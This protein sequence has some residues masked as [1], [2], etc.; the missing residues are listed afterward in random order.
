[1]YAPKRNSPVSHEPLR[2]DIE[3]ILSEIDREIDSINP[4]FSLASENKLDVIYTMAAAAVLHSIYSAFE[5]IFAL[6]QK[7]IDGRLP[8][9][10]QWHRNLL[11]AMARE[12]ELR[13]AVISEDCRDSL[14]DYLAFRHKFRHGYG[15]QLDSTKV[16]LKLTLLPQVI[17]K[18]RVEIVGFLEKIEPEESRKR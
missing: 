10:G 7:R 2:N 5:S 14:A 16:A 3:F 17:D 4:L 8:E 13:P 12:T 6:I 18:I 11:D 9:T 1:M 15:W